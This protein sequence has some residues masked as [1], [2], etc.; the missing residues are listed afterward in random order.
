[1]LSGGETKSL[2]C[3]GFTV[4]QSLLNP[5]VIPDSGL[6]ERKSEEWARLALPE[7]CGEEGAGKHSDCAAE[8]VIED[9][10]AFDDIKNCV[11]V[12]IG[13]ESEGFIIAD[14]RRRI[15]LRHRF[16]IETFVTFPDQ[17]RWNTYGT[18][19]ISWNLSLF[20]AKTLLKSIES[21]KL[22]ALQHS[23]LN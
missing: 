2:V 10:E 14:K 23:K 21:V 16:S 22:I 5:K 13:E 11:N 1:M 17:L 8:G 20:T 6:V 12:E 15:A 3:V 9:E 18:N 19:I 7:I 4:S